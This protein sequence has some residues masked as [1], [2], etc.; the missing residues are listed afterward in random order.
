MFIRTK[1]RGDRTFVQIVRS[2]REGRK[3]RQRVVRH[4]GTGTTELQADHLRQLGQVIIE[5]MR[6]EDNPQL[7]LFSP[8]EYGDLLARQRRAKRSP[9]PFGVD[10]S[11]VTEQGRVSVG[12]RD[13]FG[14]MYRL[15]GWE[16]LLGTRRMSSNR[17]IRELVL[18]RIAQP[19]GKRA[20]VREL[21]RH[22]AISL[23]LDRV[24]KAMDFLDE[25]VIGR[26]CRQSRIAA[27][28]LHGKPISVIFHD[29]TTLY[30]ESEDEDDLRRKGCSKDG[31]HHRT[32]VVLA[33]LVT[34][35]GIPCGYRLYPGNTCEGHT[36]IDALDSLSD[37]Y[38]NAR[39]TVV[40]DAGMLSADNRKRLEKR[41][42]PHILG[43]RPRSETAA[44]Q[45]RILA[46]GGFVG[47]SKADGTEGAVDRCKVIRR[48]EGGRLIIT[49]SPKRARRDAL[50]REGAIEKL[51]R[52]LAGSGRVAGVSKR[53]YA[54]FL[55]F[56]DGCVEIDEGKV[57][58]A[59]RWD[60]IGGVVAWGLDD[61]D[62]REIID[63]Y[64]GLW[65]IEA[66]F[67][68][69][70]SD[71]RIRPVFHWA[72][73]RIRAHIAI[74]CMAFCCVQHLRHRLAALGT[75]MSPD[76]IRRELNALQIG[77]IAEPESPR[78][79]AVPSSISTAARVIYRSLGIGWNTA[80]F[81]IQP[82]GTTSEETR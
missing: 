35:E 63:R 60:G 54:R 71:L 27:E 55:D 46:P 13:A 43:A 49:H 39:F 81:E 2:V 3:V 78:R 72:H 33:L 80:S 38:P 28:R 12:I 48:T 67:R 29:T 4:V 68:V 26:I 6:K 11:E 37:D 74:C 23:N 44:M 57:A 9:K 16:R 22:G 10:V 18:A 76:T 15:L 14:E 17:I 1:K 58:A 5:E 53:G 25:D 7:N 59:A 36:L 77:V 65:E 24:C 19:L 45:E 20:T 79:F 64:R 70:K 75:P 56:P 21:Y 42:I 40:A 41:K 61:L 73:R 34:P 30:F 32:Q 8:S 82:G 51:R 52:R 62:P 47:W 31:K 66:C 69:N 50:L